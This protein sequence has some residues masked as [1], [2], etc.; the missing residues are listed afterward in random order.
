MTYF[1]TFLK[2]FSIIFDKFSPYLGDV[3]VRNLEESHWW[4]FEGRGRKNFDPYIS[5]KGGCG[6]PKFYTLAPL[7]ALMADT[8]STLALGSP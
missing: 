6:A 3:H 5:P 1:G 4:N 7:Y 2:I 8:K